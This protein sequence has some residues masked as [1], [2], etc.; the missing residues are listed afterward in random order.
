MYIVYIIVENLAGRL[1]VSYYSN[2]TPLVE[3][4]GFQ[5]LPDLA[6]TGFDM[7]RPFLPKT[8]RKTCK[9]HGIF[10][11]RL[12]SS[13]PIMRPWE[14]SRARRWGCAESLQAWEWTK[15]AWDRFQE[16]FQKP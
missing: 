16:I 14:P 10:N 7:I 9:N 8:R 13:T 12:S 6:F 2:G 5:D 4:A 1:K 15:A 3:M 11:L